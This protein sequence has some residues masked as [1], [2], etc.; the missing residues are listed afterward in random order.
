MAGHP[1]GDDDARKRHIRSSVWYTVPGTLAA[2]A[3]GY[4]LLSPLRGLE[5]PS[6]RV[7]LA[8]RWLPVALL[9]YVAVCLT[10]GAKR[11]REG[12]HDPLAGAESTTLEIHRRV[13]QNTLEQFVWFAVAALALSALLGAAEARVVPVTCVVF[14]LA[15]CLY[16]HGYFRKGTLGRAPAVQITWT[17]NIAMI[18]AALGLLARSVV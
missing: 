11:L 7:L 12:S 17:L 2:V 15:R 9:P 5:E 14:A 13:M 3:A 4:A 18:L 8:L 1:L 6:A 16:W 10:I